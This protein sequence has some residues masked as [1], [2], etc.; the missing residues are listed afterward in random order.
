[1]VA[2][3][4]LCLSELL[5]PTF[6]NF[7]S[8]YSMMFRIY[9]RDPRRSRSRLGSCQVWFFRT[10]RAERSKNSSEDTMV[11]TG[12]LCWSKPI[13]PTISIFGIAFRRMC[14]FSSESC[15]CVNLFYD[16]LHVFSGTL[17]GHGHVPVVGPVKC[18]FSE[19]HELRASETSS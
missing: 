1:M 17:G 18:G 8:S 19:P 2:T 14:L 16:L 11:A 7:G 3:S 15:T 4:R 5:R 13:C 10:T 9:F 6:S 12:S